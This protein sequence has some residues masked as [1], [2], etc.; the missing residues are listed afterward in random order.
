VRWNRT[1]SPS[2]ESLHTTHQ[3]LPVSLHTA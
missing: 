2:S 3:H 1:Q